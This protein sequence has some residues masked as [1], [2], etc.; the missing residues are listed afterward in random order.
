LINIIINSIQAIP[1]SGKINII[2]RMN[3][4]NGEPAIELIIEDNGIGIPERDLPQIFDP[5]L[6]KRSR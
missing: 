6:Q 5:F 2:T 1:V 3:K 4:L